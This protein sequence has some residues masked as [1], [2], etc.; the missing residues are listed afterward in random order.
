MRSFTWATGM[1]IVAAVAACSSNSPTP[2]TMTAVSG[3]GQ[4]GTVATAISAPMVVH[5]ADQF[6]TAMSGVQVSF[7]TTG[8]AV[9]GKTL[10]NTDAS[11]NATTTVTLG[12]TIGTDTVTAFVVSLP[13][14]VDFT[15]TANPGPAVAMVIVGGNNQI[16]RAGSLL[17]NALLVEIED[18]YMNPV[19]GA[20]VDWTATGG[21]LTP[22]LPLTS[23]LNG[24]LSTAFTVPSTPLTVTVTGTL[25][26]TS[27]T[28][29]F[30]ETAD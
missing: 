11:G 1:I 12:T 29:V 9:V 2:T 7:G 4:S 13:D 14:G 23:G 22:A 19:P 25:H 6:G 30:T 5:V 26:G 10:V 21:T 15:L 18:Q 20:T 16:S 8:G 3:S 24:I 28:A 27:L 17:I